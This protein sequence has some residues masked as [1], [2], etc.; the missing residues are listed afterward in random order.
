VYWRTGKHD[1]AAELLQRWSNRLSSRDWRAIAEAFSAAF[2]EGPTDPA[3]AAAQALGK[4]QLDPTGLTS[5][6]DDTIT[7]LK[8]IAAVVPQI[9]WPGILRAT[10]ACKMYGAVRELEGEEAT[11]AALARQ[12]EG[13]PPR[14]VPMAA[15]LAEQ[16]D[17][18]W[19]YGPDP[20]PENAPAW[21]LRA[22]AYLRSDKDLKARHA[23]LVAHFQ[24]DSD[25]KDD[26][27]GRYLLGLSDRDAVWRATQGGGRSVAAWVFGQRADSEG[28]VEHAVA[29]YRIAE[30]T[31][32]QTSGE[33][34]W[35]RQA[36]PQIQKDGRSLAAVAE[37]R[38]RA[39]AER[40]R[41]LE[42]TPL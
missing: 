41:V 5:L 17:L 27:M 22:A 10:A 18:V 34:R 25:H 24:A 9:P 32:R 21:L 19:D 37:Q 7:P 13:I 20:E 16:F 6:L 1:E 15:Y 35:S 26:L 30:Q 11:R 12:V 40:A 28:D 23:K 39:W 31:G 2:G 8:L 14:V 29:W 3:V 38:K 33:V 4:R 42:S 36:L